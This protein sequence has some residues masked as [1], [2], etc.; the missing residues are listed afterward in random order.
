MR[1]L[2]VLLL[3]APCLATSQAARAVPDDPAKRLDPAAL[4]GLAAEDSAEK[5]EAIRALAIQAGPGAVPVLQAL[6]DDRLQVAGG[7]VLVADGDALRDAAT[8]ALLPAPPDGAEAVT[9]NN[10]VRR[11]LEGTL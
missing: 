3:C 1:L 11:A 8:G 5:I 2:R 6:A 10:R 4:A 7:Q 9:I